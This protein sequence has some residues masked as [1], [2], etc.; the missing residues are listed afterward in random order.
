MVD[1]LGYVV[2][3]APFLVAAGALAGLG[4]SAGR[5]GL[6]T[7]GAAVLGAAF[8]PGLGLSGVWGAL[9]EGVGIS[10]RVLYVLFGGLLLYNLLSAGGAVEEVSRFLGR[11][12]PD[13]EVL[14]VGVVV[15][16]APFFESVTGFGVAIIISTPILLSAGFSPLRAAVLAS[17]G[18]CAVPWGALG[19]GTVIGAELA[20]LEF[21]KLSDLS[22]FLSLPL[23]PVY[24]LAA[25][26]LAGGREGLRRHG[27]SA[28]VLGLVAGAATLACSVYLSP[29]LSGATGGLAAAG[30]FAGRR[31]RRLRGARIPAR[32][33]APYAFLVVLILIAE[34][35]GGGP[36][37]AG[38]GTPLLAA[39]GAAAVLLGLRG[40]Q[41]ARAAAGTMRQWLPTAGAVLSFVL[42]GQV[43]AASG[44]AATLASGAV[45][46]GGLYPAAAPV[47][48]AF[49]GGLTGS[50]AASNALFMPLQISASEALGLDEELV[51]AAQNVA[52]SHASLLAPQRAVLAA[53]AVGLAGKEAE[54]MVR[55]AP[56]VIVS[57]MVLAALGLLL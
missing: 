14:A 35:F 44:A 10:G 4:W 33:L 9:L 2:A 47:L 56:P 45:A 7:F 27:A 22:A 19:V 3:A 57:V 31:W 21:G 53:A 28:A 43:F 40:R 46:L 49:G 55:A 48:G 8:W 32:A 39:G 36:L 25:V 11:L 51:A 13:R 20:G 37:L 38:P 29:G 15:G 26:L 17:W 41:V 16:V 12:E 54:I 23:F 42:A 6:A 18:Q 34:R 52:G 1:A 24:G 30:L 5:A 50:N